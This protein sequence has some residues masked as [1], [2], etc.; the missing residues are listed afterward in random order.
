[1]LNIEPASQP[2]KQGIH[3]GGTAGHHFH[4]QADLEVVKHCTHG[5]RK[6]YFHSRKR[7][8]NRDAFNYHPS[9]GWETDR[10]FTWLAPTTKET[11]E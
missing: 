6:G 7:L 2:I 1:M 8:V 10:W 9:L 4:G 11:G 3:I 5:N